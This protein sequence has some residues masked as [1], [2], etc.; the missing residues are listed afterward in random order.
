[1]IWKK[2]RLMRKGKKLISPQQMGQKFLQ[3]TENAAS[4]QTEEDRHF[5]DPLLVFNRRSGA[6]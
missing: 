1:M 5:Q 3:I 2:A 6:A 4:S